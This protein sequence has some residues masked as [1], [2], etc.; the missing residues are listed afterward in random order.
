VK[1]ADNSRVA[2]WQVF[3][4]F[5]QPFE[6]PNTHR[7]AAWFYICSNCVNLIRTLPMMVHDKINVED[8]NTKL[9]D[10]APD[11]IRYWLKELWARRTSLSEIKTVNDVF[12]KRFEQ[13]LSNISSFIQKKPQIKKS[14]GW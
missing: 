13:E 10:H 14:E 1:G 9:E 3:R 2:G 6:D 11:A 7:I 4:Q 8:I 5:L 12:N